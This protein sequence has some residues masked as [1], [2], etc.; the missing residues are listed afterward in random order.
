MAEFLPA[1]SAISAPGHTPTR[2]VFLLHGILG[3][4][5][6]WASFARALVRRRPDLLL[7]LVDLRNH[8]DSEGALGPH[9][10]AA[11]ADDL[12]VLAAHLGAPEA[13]V[14]HSFGGKVALAYGARRPVGLR[15]IWVL[16]SPP[17]PRAVVKDSVGQ[18]VEQVIDACRF[19]PE[20]MP[21]RDAVVSH[22]LTLGFSQGLARWMT[23]NVRRRDDGFYWR[24]DLDGVEMLLEDY[25]R[26]DF[27]PLLEAP[28]DLE[29]TMVRAGRSDRWTPVQLARLAAL[30]RTR[31]E[32]IDAGHW[33]HVDNPKAL[34]ELLSADL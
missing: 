29:I 18:E 15:Q 19:L 24:F 7:V 12:D 9:T 21:D 10:L 32:V 16:D 30:K 33:V 4:K 11:C 25:W 8:G 1:F 27:W 2:R 28:G 14:G 13:V 31:V 20:P 34:L 3:S 6:N 23:T 17:G 26:R 22:F 5:G